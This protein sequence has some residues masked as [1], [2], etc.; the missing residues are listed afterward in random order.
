MSRRVA[1]DLHVHSALS[2]CGS[3]EM[4]PPAVLLTA[5]RRGI[6]VLGVVDHSSAANAPA[7]LAA[8]QAF[9]V[10][11]LVGLEI[12]SAE[13]VHIL[14][15]F[16]TAEG[17]LEM[18]AVVAGHLPHLAN[19]RE[20][21]GAQFVVDEMG[22]V[23]GEEE[24]LLIAA[25]DLAIEH[26][27]ELTLERGGLSIPAHIDR[28]ANGLLPTLGFVPPDLRVDLFEVSPHLTR[29]DAR[30]QWP[31]LAGRALVSSSDAHFLE[32]IGRSVTWAPAELARRELPLAEWAA[33][34]AEGL[35][36]HDDDE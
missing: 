5:E 34:L 12:E 11:V 27:A 26:I 28:P 30:T 25:T 10:R 7:F 22:K 13:G 23:V 1:M 16:D 33:R 31:E 14:A 6:A 36:G 2:P 29:T 19:R 18:D 20:I 8:A 21:L 35:R 24:R 17:A 9:E 15:L 32:S 3:E 4:R